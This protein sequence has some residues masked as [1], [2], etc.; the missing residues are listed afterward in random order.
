M[1]RP[2]ATPAEIRELASEILARPEYAKYRTDSAEQWARWIDELLAWIS[3]L[4]DLYEDSPGLYWLIVGL[5]TL[6]MLA[7]IAHIAWSIAV[8]L[9]RSQ[10]PAEAHERPA[11]PDV[12]A[13]A[14]ELAGRGE[15]LEAAHQLLLASL[16]HAARARVL[17]LRPED[18]NSR[19]CEKLQASPLAPALRTRLIAL[20]ERTDASWFGA[21]DAGQA[22]YEQWQALYAELRSAA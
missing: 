18:G 7:L 1:P 14:A 10:A 15:H 5:L 9:R 19:V 20:I 13:L 12:P 21:R 2:G 3:R 22:L 6:V 4:K 11:D 17:E 16:A 8:A